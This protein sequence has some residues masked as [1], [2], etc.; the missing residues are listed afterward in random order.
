[1]TLGPLLST[2]QR[3]KGDDWKAL[4]F[5]AFPISLLHSSSPS[6]I[7]L[8][9][10]NFFFLFIKELGLGVWLSSEHVCGTCKRAQVHF[11]YCKERRVTL[12]VKVHAAKPGDL[13][14][15]PE[16]LHVG[17]KELTGISC[18]LTPICVHCN[19]SDGQRWKPQNP[20]KIQWP[21]WP[22][23]TVR[24]WVME[25]GTPQTKLPS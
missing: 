7:K 5:K 14:S 15:N 19:K 12:W 8:S 13:S 24:I 16:I 3:S 10:C 4:V 17:R 6:R 11:R 22:A 18:L 25:T 9:F 20:H 1:M 21:W 23:C 2:N